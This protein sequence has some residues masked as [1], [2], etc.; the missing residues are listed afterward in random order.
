M[1]PLVTI[2]KQALKILPIV[3]RD[4]YG[5]PMVRTLED[6]MADQTTDRAKWIVW[7]RTMLD[8]P[9]TTA[10]QY[11]QAGGKTMHQAP[12]YAKQ[13]TIL[14]VALLVPFFIVITLNSI[15]PLTKTLNG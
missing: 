12:N 2:Y 11:A 8:L 6:M 4:R 14:S 13:G 7:S 5:E 9:I 3:Y 10:Y 15:H 1:K